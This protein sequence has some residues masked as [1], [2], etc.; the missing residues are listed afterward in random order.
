MPSTSIYVIIMSL[1]V[2]THHF[3]TQCASSTDMA[4]IREENCS[5]SGTSRHLVVVTAS[6]EQVVSAKVL[7]CTN[8]FF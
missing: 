5:L 1:T 4:T 3:E 8:V 6:G 7:L 2:S